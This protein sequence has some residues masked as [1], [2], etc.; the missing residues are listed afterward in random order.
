MVVG[1]VIFFLKNPFDFFSISGVY[2]E[3]YPLLIFRIECFWIES[4]RIKRFLI[5]FADRTFAELKDGAQYHRLSSWILT[6]ASRHLADL[7]VQN[8]KKFIIVQ[9]FESL[10]LSF[11]N[12]PITKLNTGMNSNGYD[13]RV[14][15]KIVLK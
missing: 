12:Y 15:T 8:W 4:F 14:R 2:H 3:R 11:G 1:F 6:L 7:T 13:V 10:K 5:K 9:P